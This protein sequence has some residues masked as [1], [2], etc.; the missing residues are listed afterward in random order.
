MGMDIC[1][2]TDHDLPTENLN[3]FV[4]EFQKQTKTDKIIATTIQNSFPDIVDKNDDTWYIFYENSNHIEILSN[5]FNI[6]VYKKTIDIVDFNGTCINWNT[7]M[8]YLEYDIETAKNWHNEIIELF[9]QFIVPIFHSTKLMLLADSF[10]ERHEK[11]IDYIIDEGKTIEEALT[12]NKTFEK[13]CKVYRD[14]NIFGIKES[15]YWDGDFGPIF[16]INLT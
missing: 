8:R 11:L 14:Q 2:I 13:P 5:Q 10:C 1:Y 7:M 12:L 4:K 16:L 15:E 3:E 6:Y 9:K